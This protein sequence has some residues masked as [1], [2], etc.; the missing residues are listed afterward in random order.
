MLHALPFALAY[1]VPLTAALGL[2]LGGPWTFATP[3]LIFVITPV[4]DALLGI[5]THN[6]AG[7]DEE[8]A[9]GQVRLYDLWL[10]LWVPV[11]LGLLAWALWQVGRGEL[12]ALELVGVTLSIGLVGGAG[13]ITIAHELMHRKAAWAQTSAEVLMTAVSYPHFCIEHVHG[14]HRTVA[15]PLD[16]ATSRL[17]ESVYAFWPRV[18]RDSLRSFLAIE[19]GRVAK[20][21]IKPGSWHDARAR[22]ATLLAAAIGLA[23]ALGSLAG[24]PLAVPGALAFFAAQSLVGFTLLEIVNYVE[25]YGLQ[26]RELAPGKYER[27]LPKHSWNSPHRLTCWYLFNLPRH[28]DH[29]YL[30]SRPYWNLRHMDDSPQLPA[31]YATMVLLALAPRWWFRVMDPRVAAW[32]A[33]VSEAASTASAGTAATSDAAEPQ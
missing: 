29:H 2:W 13:G 5:D 33:R 25:H 15:T 31:G 9:R 12:T 19:A 3:L 26:R 22:Y 6:P 32:N 1:L 27:V 28:A 17:G 10:V 23:G 20:R 4:L 16:P 21:G 24:G 7:P 14:H 8:R 30:A 11:Q 18:V